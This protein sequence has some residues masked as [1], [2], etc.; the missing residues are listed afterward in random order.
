MRKSN[1]QYVAMVEFDSVN[2]VAE[3]VTA[4]HRHVPTLRNMDSQ[5]E[6]Y[7]DNISSMR[8]VETLAREGWDEKNDDWMKIAEDTLESIE[9]SF[10]VPTWSS[11]YDVTG[12]DVDVSR[13]LIGEPENMIQF[14]LVQSTKVGR[15]V[16]IAVNIVASAV[17]SAETIEA[18]GKCVM[19]LV[20]ALERIGIRTEIYADMQVSEWTFRDAK[21]FGRIITKVKD[22]GEVLDP[23]M[24]SYAL[25]HASFFR[26]LVMP[27][28]HEFPRAIQD[29]IGVGDGYGIPTN[30]MDN[31]G[32]FPE[33][34]IQIESAMYGEW[35]RTKAEDFVVRHLKELGMI[36]D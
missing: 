6:W 22:A 33:G 25:A 18:R 31:E 34:T 5:P 15:V 36:T 16:S 11:H 32:V 24:V 17:V 1:T 35:D 14:D 19:A 4:K 20:F 30:D 10:D 3:L 27:A 2:E 21:T 7:G 23:A 12:S 8:D 13:Y 28:M 29:E 26:A 9:R